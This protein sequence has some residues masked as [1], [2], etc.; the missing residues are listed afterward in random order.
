MKGEKENINKNQQMLSKEVEATYI[1]L[2]SKRIW[3]SNIFLLFCIY[4]G[5]F[6]VNSVY[7]YLLSDDSVLNDNRVKLHVYSEKQ[8]HNTIVN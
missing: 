3:W 2:H 7:K 6:T 4:F 5:L 8:K 1:Y